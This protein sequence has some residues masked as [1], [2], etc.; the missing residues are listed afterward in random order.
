M[1][2]NITQMAFDSLDAPVAVVG[3]RNW[4][5]PC[6]EMEEAFFPQKEWILDTIH[7][8][9]LPLPGHTVTHR[10]GRAGD[11]AE[12]P[13]R[14]CEARVASGRPCDRDRLDRRGS[15]S[16]YS[17]SM[18]TRKIVRSSCACRSFSVCRRLRG[19]A[20]A[21]GTSPPTSSAMQASGR[22]VGSMDEKPF[23][24]AQERKQ[25]FLDQIQAMLDAR[26]RRGGPR[27]HEG[28]PGSPPG[29]LHVRLRGGAQHGAVARTRCPPREWKIGYGSVLT[30]YVMQAYMTAKCRPKPTDVSLEIGTGS[31]FQSSLLSRI[32]KKAYTIEIITSLGDK[33]KNIFAPLGYD[34]IESRVGDGFFGWPEVKDG[35]DIIL[36]TAQAPFVPPALLAQLKKGGRMIIPIGQPWKPQ[37]L[38]I[39]TKDEQGKVH[40]QRDVSTLF[41]PMTG[42]DPDSTAQADALMSQRRNLASLFLVSLFGLSFE[43]F[44]SRYF[45][46]ALFSDYSYWVISLALLGYSFGGVFLT[47]L[48]GPLPPPH[49]RVPAAHPA[50]CCWRRA[51]LAFLMLRANPFNPLQLQNEVLWKSQIGNIF[52]YYAG[53]FPVFFLTGDVHRADLPHLQQRDPARLRGGSPGRG[54][55]A[56]P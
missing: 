11:A 9:V 41:I 15:S 18:T 55:A 38:Y 35:F 2:S 49:A 48:P 14:A 16:V 12:E 54:R 36:V 21:P 10:P 47:L 34:N 45:A 22:Q 28:V 27:G 42:A 13:P 3:A 30:D 51:S 25:K 5:T 24:A 4:I 50:R 33:V 32:V 20:A 29:I 1:A 31:G 40:S 56:P 17:E 26:L 52:L 37:F 43:T 46:L 7:E 19:G 6:A 23:Q 53:L 39:F 44:L 8:R